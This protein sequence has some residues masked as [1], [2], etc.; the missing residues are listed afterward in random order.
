[1]LFNPSSEEIFKDVP[2]WFSI[3]DLIKNLPKFLD[4][5]EDNQEI[6]FLL[7]WLEKVYK[8]YIEEKDKNKNLTDEFDK[9]LKEIQKSVAVI[10]EKSK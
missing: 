5:N 6:S 2:E 3:K 8:L 9:E 7:K 1:M 4:A 10:L